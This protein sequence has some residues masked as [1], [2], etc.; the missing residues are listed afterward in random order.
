[1]AQNADD[2]ISSKGMDK[3]IK[4]KTWTTKRIAMIVGGIAVLA[5]FIYSFVFMDMRSTLNVDRDKLTVSTVTKDSFQEFIQVTGTVQPIRTIYL[6]AVEGGVVKDVDRE[7]GT[8]VDKGDTIL[9]MNNSSLRLNVMQ[10]TTGLYDQINNVRNSR[11]NIQQNSLQLKQELAN[12]KSQMEILKSK[13]ERQKKL[14]EQN[15]I[16]E[17]DFQETKENYQYQKKRYNLTYESYRQDSIRTLSQLKQLD[18]SEDRMI[19]NLNAT[20]EILDNLVVTAPISGQL[21]T[22]ELQQG[23][24]INQG[25]RLGQVDILDNYKVRVGIDEY[26]LSRITTGLKGSF[27]FAGKTHQLKITKVYPVVNNGQ[28][29]VDMEFVNEPP[30]GLTRGQ[31]VRIRLELGESSKAVLLPRGGFY[32]TTGG[33]WVYK[34]TDD[35]SKAVKQQINLG[36]QNPDYFEVLSGLKPGDKVITSSYDTFGDNEV[37]NLQ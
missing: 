30:S 11:L 12:A 34:I 37:L 24:S 31:T 7:S 9:T 21:S 26:H 32:Q 36:R 1:M 4:K 13:Y 22:V 15:L 8:M 3:K 29:Q 20:Q 2:R 28:F 33:N 6:D 14:H 35:G 23:Q 18:R 5:L 25:E 17:Q 16:S 27:D 10:Q 19:R